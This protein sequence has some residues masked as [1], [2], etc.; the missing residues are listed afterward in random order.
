[1][2]KYGNKAATNNPKNIRIMDID[3]DKIEHLK[4]EIIRISEYDLLHKDCPELQIESLSYMVGD[5]LS[6]NKNGENDMLIAFLTHVGK[7]L[8]KLIYY[9]KQEENKHGK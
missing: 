7:S 9:Q 6:K 4:S 3:K 2:L 5:L 1:M 8:K